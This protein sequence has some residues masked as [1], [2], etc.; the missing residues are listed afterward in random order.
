MRG[1][2]PCGCPATAP[3]C[4][5]RCRSSARWIGE[6]DDGRDLVLASHVYAD[7]G[8]HVRLAAA[9]DALFA[10]LPGAAY[11]ALATPTDCYLA[12]DE[13]VREARRRWERRGALRL[14]QAP[15]RAASAGRLLRP[16]YAG[17]RR[18]ADGLV[19][20]QGPNYAL[21][22][23]VQR[24]RAAQAAA[25]GRTV[26]L[27]L[28][29][30][31]ATRSVTRHRALLA[32]YLGARHF[33]V[34]VFAPATTRALMAA[35]PRPRPALPSGSR[36]GRARAQRRPRRP[37]ADPVRAALR[38][39]A[40]RAGRT[41]ALPART[42]VMDDR[43]LNRALLARQGLL[44]RIDAPLDEALER[45]GAV[46]AQSWPA[47]AVALW[48]RVADFTPE[49]LYAALDDGALVTG[50][51][52]RGTVHLMSAREH[53]LYAGVLEASGQA[54]PWRT[55]AERGKDAAKLRP[56][57]AKAAKGKVLGAK[58]VAEL[59]EAWVAEHP[60]AIPEEE[61]AKQRAVSWRTLLRGGD[62]VRVP[63]SGEWGPKAPDA[64]TGPPK[65][66]AKGKALDA[67]VLAHLRAFGPAGADDIAAWIG[68]KAG[69][70]RE[71][72]ERVAGDLEELEHGK[73]TLY[74][75]RDGARPDADT[76]APPRY[77]AAFDSAILAY[78]PKRRSRLVPEGTFEKIYNRANL[79]IRPTFLLD[80]FVAG[81]WSA[82]VK[83]KKATLTFSPFARLPRGA[84]GALTDEGEALLAGVHPKATNR[85]VKQG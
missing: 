62:L 14:L 53:P 12:P 13:A 17:G 50:L 6:H 57:I 21:A 8:A 3:T 5:P 68:W 55:K 31:T 36:G 75:V 69:P 24:W 49:R 72:I 11:A 83:G 2:A 59:A 79:Q 22:K 81:T 70:V 51:V 44:E 77:L 10:D 65:V 39:A 16:A 38:P 26:S 34:E 78:A 35:P 40:R 4:S 58:D 61:L 41:P 85:A 64:V 33:G 45:I 32:A 73:R 60:D 9:A 43:E 46:Q 20:Q 7:G 84:K 23:R 42:S 48:T 19:R 71:A 76:E 1:R 25:D 37:V 47:A 66:K 67:V 56:A 18:L 52:H 80:G 27:N 28:A 15:L 29:P 63:S 30:A 82:E 54:D 74:D